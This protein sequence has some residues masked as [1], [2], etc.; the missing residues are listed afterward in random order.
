MMTK[1]EALRIVGRQ[2]EWALKNMAVALA[3]IPYLNDADDWERLE[4][5][6]LVLGGKAPQKARA[7]IRARSE[8]TR[9]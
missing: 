7:L 3:L 6:V 4:A 8:R 1:T 2:P 5:A 9:Q